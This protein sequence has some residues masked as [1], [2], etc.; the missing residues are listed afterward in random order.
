[1]PRTPYIVVLAAAMTIVACG[2]Q[3]T[4]PSA[5]RLES[6]P[7]LAA[8]APPP[9]PSPNVISTL[10]DVDAAGTALLT[11]S[12]DFNGATSA[13]YTAVNKITSHISESGGW[14]LYIG[15]QTART[16]R[17]TLASQGIPLPD[18]NYS[19]NVEVYSGCFDAS[20][21]KISI[22]TMTVGAAYD[23]CSFGLD[24]SSGRTKYK[25][26]MGPAYAGT[27]RAIVTC[28]AAS[29]G[30]C[31]NWTIVPDTTIAN[32]RVANLFHFAN[33]GSLILDGVYH[34]SFSV[35]VA[36]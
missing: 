8:K 10:Y 16:I 6:G 4:T 5:S 31:T 2:D 35:G 23:N 17:L 36:Q 14:Q 3:T 27:G 34:N 18:G 25:L 30:Q 7:V 32:A 9:P 26:V 33:N 24:F 12:D 11:R 1:M 28:T 20:N 19:S 22:L 13:T 29:G 15:N 21:T